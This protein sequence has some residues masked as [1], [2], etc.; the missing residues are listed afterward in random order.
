MCMEFLIA[1]C[2]DDFDYDEDIFPKIYVKDWT[3]FFYGDFQGTWLL[4]KWSPENST[5]VLCV[6]RARRYTYEKIRLFKY[7]T[8]NQKLGIEQM[9]KVPGEIEIWYLLEDAL[10]K[11]VLAYFTIKALV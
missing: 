4:L 9:N 6:P 2:K 11:K 5:S 8:I 7:F 10:W 3:E 1:G